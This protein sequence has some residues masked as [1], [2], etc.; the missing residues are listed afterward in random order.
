NKRKERQYR[1]TPTFAKDTIGGLG[2]FLYYNFSLNFSLNPDAF[3]KKSRN[4]VS[5]PAENFVQSNPDLYIDFKIPWNIVLSYQATYENLRVKGFI[6]NS[7]QFS[8]DLSITENWKLT[9][10]SSYDILNKVLPGGNIGIVRDL[11]CWSM[12]LNVSQFGNEYRYFF[13]IN[14]KSS[15]LQDLKLTKR[16]PGLMNNFMY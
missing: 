8:G 12:S 4:D 1:R 5:T 10:N 15:L 11:H 9:L 14:A 2:R 13:N 7:I 6:T 3:K 16:S